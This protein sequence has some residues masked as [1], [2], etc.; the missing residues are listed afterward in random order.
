MTSDMQRK[1]PPTTLD[2]EAATKQCRTL[3]VRAG[4]A[5]K[6]LPLPRMLDELSRPPFKA[7]GQLILTEDEKEWRDTDRELVMAAMDFVAR[8]EVQIKRWQGR[9]PPRGPGSTLPPA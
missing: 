9:K 6:K 4:L 1:V 2:I 5:L 7:G 8:V 3:V